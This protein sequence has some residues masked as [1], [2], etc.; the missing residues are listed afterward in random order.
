MIMT[1]DHGRNIFL[2][3]PKGEEFNSWLS[4]TPYTGPVGV[5]VKLYVKQV[6]Q[7][8]NRQILLGASISQ[9]SSVKKRG[10]IFFSP[11]AAGTIFARDAG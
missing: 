5:I 8:Q 7:Y 2:Y 9:I 11:G 6:K 10:R 4:S 1:N 3:Q